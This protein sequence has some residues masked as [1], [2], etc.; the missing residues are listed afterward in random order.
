[1]YVCVFVKVNMTMLLVM[2]ISLTLCVCLSMSLLFSHSFSLSFFLPLS[3]PLSLPPSLPP[4]LP[5]KQ[6]QAESGA[7]N[8][9]LHHILAKSEEV[10]MYVCVFAK[11]N[12]TML[13]VMY[14]SFTLSVSIFHPL[15]LC[16]VAISFIGTWNPDIKTG[17]NRVCKRYTKTV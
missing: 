8:Y 3:F 4:C 15:S 5:V 6:T 11:V 17:A 7:A 2:Y 13:L 9:A 14:I 1:M 16:H 12:L 10:W